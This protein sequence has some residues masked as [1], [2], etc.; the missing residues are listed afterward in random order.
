[1]VDQFCHRWS[2][3]SRAIHRDPEICLWTLQG[4]G[5]ATYPEDFETVC[6]FGTKALRLD[7]VSES[8]IFSLVQGGAKKGTIL[9]WTD[10]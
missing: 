9:R 3:S 5:G 4:D 7:N 1:M 8:K 10:L 6:D 2:V